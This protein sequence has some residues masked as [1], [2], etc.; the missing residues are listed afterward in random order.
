MQRKHSLIIFAG[1]VEDIGAGVRVRVDV[2]ED[3]RTVGSSLM[4]LL[5]FLNF[6]G[7]S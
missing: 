5:F 4:G 3:V 1:L 7:I 6:R 2:E